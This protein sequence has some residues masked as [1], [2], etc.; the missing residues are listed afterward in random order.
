MKKS[1]S[2]EMDLVP[3]VGKTSL[4]VSG[5]G[6]G[7]YCILETRPI[8]DEDM[9][10]SGRDRIFLTCP[11]A[12]GATARRIA[13]AVDRKRSITDYLPTGEMEMG[14]AS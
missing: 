4:E 7:S 10:R 3:P 11:M 1:K 12:A 5:R 9:M 2:F 6:M 14:F 8:L 13:R